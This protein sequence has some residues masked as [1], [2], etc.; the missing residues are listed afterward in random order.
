MSVIFKP[1]RPEIKWHVFT[2]IKIAGSAINKT[3]TKSV[4]LN[5]SLPTLAR[6]VPVTMSRDTHG[7]S[8]HSTNHAPPILPTSAAPTL[9][10]ILLGLN[11]MPHLAGLRAVTHP[12]LAAL[13]VPLTMLCV[14]DEF[15]H[16]FGSGRGRS[17]RA[18]IDVRSRLSRVWHRR[19]TF[20]FVASCVVP[21]SCNALFFLISSPGLASWP[22][23]NHLKR[24]FTFP[25]S[26][27]RSRL[28]PR[29]WLPPRPRVLI[30][31][32]CVQ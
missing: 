8:L 9:R 7:Q 6:R 32:A 20:F 10:G 19:G 21:C 18:A 14:L 27:A 11:L 15:D 3:R 30:L 28:W 29:P 22:R 2:D 12:S 23:C 31:A 24:P 16:S 13:R 5:Q 26:P 17:A 1:S 4:K 25:R